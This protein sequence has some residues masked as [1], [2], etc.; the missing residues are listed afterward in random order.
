VNRP[1]SALLETALR[2]ARKAGADAC[3]AMLHERRALRVR[4]RE[5]GVDFAIESREAAL[6]IRAL[7]AGR[8]G[9]AQAVASTRDLRPEAVEETAR[10]AV[11]LAA[12]TAPDPAVGLPG[13]P[14]AAPAGTLEPAEVGETEIRAEAL[15]EAALRAEEAALAADARITRSEGSEAGSSEGLIAFASSEGFA[16]SYRVTRFE[17]SSSPVAEDATGKQTDTWRSVATRRAAL[18]D[19]AAVGVEAA[20]R[21]LARL[22]SRRVPTCEVPVIFEHRAAASLLR[23]L[24][25]CVSGQAV[26]Q[27]ASCLAK[28]R[29]R[30][31]APAHFSVTDDPTLAD[32][33]ASRPFDGEGV[34]SRRTPVIASGVLE[35]FLL[36]HRSARRLGSTTTGHARRAP[37][38]LPAP[39]PTN[40]WLEPGSGDLDDLISDTPR[41][42]LVTSLFGHGFDPVSGQVSRGACGHWIEGGR[43]VHPVEE[44]TVAGNLRD[45]LAGVDAVA[46]DLLVTGGVASPSFRVGSMT[47]GGD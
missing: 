24:A 4:V 29:G 17:L 37:D 1:P 33:L 9:L 45:L 2:A 36:D 28:A 46:G 35:S 20:R 22:G 6:G 15:A 14:A 31:L 32:G 30:T 44:I 10:A 40:F 12:A 41:G 25:T 38:S 26:C 27:Q 3:D 43:L 23:H 47:V 13:P 21:A 18:S 5:G 19:P 7:R 11:R 16:G 39:G 42:L 34:A 8:G